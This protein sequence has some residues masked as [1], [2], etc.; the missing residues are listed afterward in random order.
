MKIELY[1]MNPIVGDLK[2]NTDKIL[3]AIK[4]AL[5]NG[6]RMIVFPEL[7]L[8]GYPPEDLLLLPDFISA[9]PIFLDKIIQASKDIAVLVGLPRVNESK[10]GKSLYNSAAIIDNRTLLGFHDKILLPTYDVFDERRYFEPG[11][12]CGIWQ[13][14]SLKVAVAICEDLWE[15]SGL[16]GMT[17][18]RD[19]IQE[20]TTYSPDL[21]VNLS[22]SPYSLKKLHSRINTC[23]SSAKTLDCPILY[24]NQVGA[25]DS[26]IYDGYSL[27]VSP[28]GLLQL[29]KGFEEDKLL[30][31][32]S[33]SLEPI[34]F[35]QN[36]VKDLY[37]ALVL[38]TKDYL[39]KLNIRKACLGL[40]GGID[41]AVVACI[42]AEAIGPENVTALIMP[43]RYSAKESMR[44]AEL[45]AKNLGINREQFS[46]EQP[47]CAYLDLLAP[48][49]KEKGEDV[50]EENIQARIRGMILMAFSNKFGCILLNTG[51]K[52][53][54][55][56]G[57]ATLY[58]DMCGGLSV[59]G[60]LLKRQV[61]QIAHWINRQKEI[62]PEHTIKREPSAELKANQRDSDTLPPYEILDNVVQAYVE[63]S[64]SHLDIVEKFNYPEDIV[65][66]IIRMIH[67]NEYKRRQ[68]APALRISEKAFSA[69]H[70]F[71][72][73]QKWVTS[74]K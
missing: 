23:L 73:V 69:G 35:Q 48:F 68:A 49:L 44:D 37:N 66:K 25:N 31:D 33:Q 26:L 51:N 34:H 6:I 45:L 14:D 20:L 46:I 9:I 43:S 11:E 4:D 59:I 63:E 62:I 55:A 67:R 10:R 38:G 56:A 21:L 53:E 18:R 65:E 17:Y 7:A 30:V 70:R 24:C 58:G 47:F 72:I 40:S 41:S 8:T 64:K 54:L 42:A 39:K 61:Y 57:Y 71:P 27:H 1:Q 12:Q 19:P 16:L 22:S 5:K 32:L 29:G 74:Y 60:D 52:S 13:I 3:S 2:G 15:H 50:T 28:K 36:E